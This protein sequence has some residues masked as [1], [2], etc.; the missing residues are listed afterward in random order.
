MGEKGMGDFQFI[1][2]I[3]ADILEEA[4]GFCS[5]F[6]PPLDKSMKQ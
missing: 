6:P 5:F 2:P 1:N 3:L 4:K